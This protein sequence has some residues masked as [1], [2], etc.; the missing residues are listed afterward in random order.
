MGAKGTDG[1]LKC[2]LYIGQR[3]KGEYGALKLSVVKNQKMSQTSY[4]RSP[5]CSIDDGIVPCLIQLI[6]NLFGHNFRA[7]C[8]CTCMSSHFSCVRLFGHSLS[9]SS[10][11][12][13]LQARILALFAMN[14][15]RD[16][17]DPKTEP[18]SLYLLHWQAGS[19][20]L[21]PPGKPRMPL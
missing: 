21:V 8:L 10:I 19:L 1:F 7:M 20:P 4:Y 13:I 2:C 17:P 14:S 16:L 5:H 9:D 15:S 6:L 18:A 3:G 11:Q 12:G